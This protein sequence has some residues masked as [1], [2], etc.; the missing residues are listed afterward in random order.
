MIEKILRS[1]ITL[2][3]SF[4][5]GGYTGMYHPDYARLLSPFAGLYL[6]ALQIAVIPI[7]VTSTSANIARI[8][9]SDHVHLIKNILGITFLF[10]FGVSGLGIVIALITKPGVFDEIGYDLAKMIHQ[11]TASLAKELSLTDLIEPSGMEFFA[12][13]IKDILPS[14]IISAL[15]QGQI[16]QIIVFS[17]IFGIAVAVYSKRKENQ[18][19]EFLDDLK[20]T[21]QIIINRIIILLPIGVF[22]LLADQF[23]KISPEV[24]LALLKFLI[25]SIGTFLLLALINSFFIWRYS[26]MGYWK[27]W[28]QLKDP[29]VIAFST[30]NSLVA[31]PTAIETLVYKFNLDKSLTNSLM[32]LGISICRYGNILYFTFATIFIAQLYSTP[33]ELSSYFIILV[34]SIIAGIM[35]SGVSGAATLYMMTFILD[36]VGLPFDAVL[37]L[38]IAI[39][40]IVDPLRSF[41]NVHTN[42]AT[43]IVNTSLS[44]TPLYAGKTV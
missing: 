25:L 38:F 30:R 5:L 11:S 15:A 37:I 32:T 28:Y 2:F 21:F 42:C 20:S 1:P 19:L 43:T 41:I 6:A 34:T 4:V 13:F 16:L 33:L 35:T 29:I 9:G 18:I 12:D 17:I 26:S 40:T 14:N 8:A 31:L 7:I 23:A 36:P 39:D 10:L 24:I 3:I 27:S 22:F 44:E